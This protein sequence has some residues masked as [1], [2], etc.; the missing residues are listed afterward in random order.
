MAILLQHYIVMCERSSSKTAN[1]RVEPLPTLTEK[2]PLL[3]AKFA[4]ENQIL[5]KRFLILM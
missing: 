3:I 4:C 2:F 1:V 5:L